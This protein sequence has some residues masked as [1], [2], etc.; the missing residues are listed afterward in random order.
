LLRV[1]S[2]GDEEDPD[3]PE[4]QIASDPDLDSPPISKAKVKT[5]FQQQAPLPA[6]QPSQHR[7]PQMMSNNPVLSRYEEQAEQVYGFAWKVGV[8]AQ[9]LQRQEKQ[10]QD[11]LSASM[12]VFNAPVCCMICMIWMG[13]CRHNV[14]C[15]LIGKGAAAPPPA[16]AAMAAGTTP[17]C[18][19]AMAV[20]TTEAFC[21]RVLQADSCGMSAW[22]CSTQ[23]L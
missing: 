15:C 7:L 5:A 12:V 13:S 14:S 9:Q 11:S 4:V 6:R 3:E 1:A 2:Q 8:A 17:V 19:S 21:K 10:R 23:Q 20:A 22:H 18:Y 16:A